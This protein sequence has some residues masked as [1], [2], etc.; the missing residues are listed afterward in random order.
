MNVIGAGAGGWWKDRPGAQRRLVERIAA[1]A[2]VPTLVVLEGRPV[3]G[4][5]EGERGPVRVAWA[6]RAGR[7][8]ADDRIVEEVGLASGPVTVVTADREL[9]RRVAGLGA[10]VVGP[11]GLDRAITGDLPP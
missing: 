1:E 10:L 9:K 6:R 4:L 5:E 7:D 2:C 8:A 3:E 11:S